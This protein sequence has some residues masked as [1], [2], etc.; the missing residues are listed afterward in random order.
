M[1]AKDYTREGAIIRGSRWPPVEGAKPVEITSENDWPPEAEDWA[2]TLIFSRIA[3]IS[4]SGGAPK[5][6][7]PADAAQLQTAKKI[8]CLFHME[9]A[10]SVRMPGSSLAILRVEVKSDDGSPNGAGICYY[11][12]VAGTARVRNPAGEGSS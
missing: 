4:A 3:S 8:V 1:V 5:L 7:V 9:P 2:W 10:D 6:E 12:C 11:D